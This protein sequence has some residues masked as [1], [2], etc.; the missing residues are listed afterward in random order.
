MADEKENRFVDAGAPRHII[1]SPEEIKEK[2][3]DEDND[4]A[5]EQKNG[6]N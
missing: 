3:G 1:L 4:E 2:F 6:G 5:N